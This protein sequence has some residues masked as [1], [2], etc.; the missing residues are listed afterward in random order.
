MQNSE[1]AAKCGLTARTIERKLK[2]I[3]KIL[4][5]KHKDLETLAQGLLE[6]ETL[7]GDDITNL[8]K[9]I[10]PK[11]DDQDTGKKSGKSGSSVPRAGAKRGRG[12][13]DMEP[14]PQS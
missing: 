5:K 14:Q 12:A 13:G 4:T 7:S 3:R 9:G 6:Y 8:L 1:I 10:A 11:R 2:L